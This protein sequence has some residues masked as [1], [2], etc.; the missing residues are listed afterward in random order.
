MDTSSNNN[1]NV[2]QIKTS[3][4]ICFILTQGKLFFQFI[5]LKIY[6][7]FSKTVYGYACLQQFII[8]NRF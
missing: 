2:F 8:Y 3:Q 1:L 6:Y 7:Q 5:E 4:Y